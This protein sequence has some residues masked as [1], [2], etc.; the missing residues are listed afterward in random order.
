MVSNNTTKINTRHN[1]FNGI[2]A[3]Y[4]RISKS[5][6]SKH[7]I[8]EFRTL[9]LCPQLQK[10]RAGFCMLHYVRSLSLNP[11]S[12]SSSAVR[13]LREHPRTP[14]EPP[15]VTIA[16]WLRCGF[17]IDDKLTCYPDHRELHEFRVYTF[18]RRKQDSQFQNA[19]GEEIE[20][21]PILIIN[22]LVLKNK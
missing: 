5:I 22:F 6:V 14:V 8:V 20:F 1:M 9:T 7:S 4:V 16:E 10:R 2:Q 3:K 19:F 11:Q 15:E 17:S 21:L 18:C 13:T 12:H